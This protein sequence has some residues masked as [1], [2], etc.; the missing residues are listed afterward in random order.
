M[1]LT[2][3]IIA[4]MLAAS[5]VALAESRVAV[6]GA[7]ITLGDVAEAS[8]PLAAVRVA[9]SPAIG[10]SL[11]LDPAFIGKIARENGVYYPE[12]HDGPIRITRMSAQQ[13]AM[14]D[15]TPRPSPLHAL[16]PI[17][18]ISRGERLS[19]DMLTWIETGPSLRMPSVAPTEMSAAI[20]QEAKR[21][22]RAGRPFQLRDITEPSVIRKGDPVTLIYARAG[23]KLTVT[24]RALSDAVLGGHVRVMNNHSNRTIDAIASGSGVAEVS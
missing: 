15:L 22:L 13:L 6:T 24:G 12:N 17:R 2:A 9:P 7:W 11:S 18:D 10:E 5:P 14:Q 19:A 3:S 16:A 4:L 8:G 1:R 23:L 20:G 21:M